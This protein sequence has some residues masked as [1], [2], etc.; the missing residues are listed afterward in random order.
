[1]ATLPVGHN[2]LW[3]PDIPKSQDIPRAA[4]VTRSTADGLLCLT[5]WPANTTT[6]M[7]RREVR[8][9]HDPLLKVKPQLAKD[10]DN[11][12]G[13]WDYVQQAS[14]TEIVEP[15]PEEP[16]RL[17]DA[18]IVEMV[19]GLRK[20]GVSFPDVGKK[21]SK[22]AGKEIPWQTLRKMFRDVEKPE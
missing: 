13:V 3:Y 16:S 22:A 17:T 8:Y 1:M 15:Q 6:P 18:E 12:Y 20:R 21:V 5:I 7:L 9:R 11:G 19:K 14:P 10:G 2:C 4:I